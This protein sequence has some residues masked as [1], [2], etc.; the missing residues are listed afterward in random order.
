MQ[1]AVDQNVSPERP[2]GSVLVV[3]DEEQIRRLV[4][5]ALRR[6]GYEVTVAADGEE[7]LA[8]IAEATPDLVVSDVMMPGL[9]GFALLS[10][11]R[12]DPATR[13]IPVILL[14]AKGALE[15]R[16]TGLTLGADDYLPKPF[17]MA[18][19]L[20]RVR[21]KIERPPVPSDE[22]PRDRQTRL[23][24]ERS[25]LNALGREVERASRSGRTGILAFL[26][27][28]ELP[29]IRQ[30]LGT[31]AD[32]AVAKQFASLLL[33]EA[34][35]LDVVARD[36]EGRFAMLIPEISPEAA[37]KRLELL[38]QRIVQ[39]TFTAAGEQVRLT[40]VIGFATFDGETNAAGVREQALI[41]LAVAEIR[42]DLQPV[43]YEP[44]LSV[45]VAN[46][47]AG[48]IRRSARWPKR[49]ALRTP[50]QIVFTYLLGMGVP[51]LAYF[52]FSG[53]GIDV[54]Q[55]MYCVVVVSLLVTSFFIW[56]EGFEALR[57]TEIPAQPGAPYPPATA[58]IAAYLPNEA[59][60]IAD[61]IEAFLR[62]EYPGPLQIILAYNTPRDLPVEARLREIAQRDS[63]FLPLRVRQSTSKAQNVNAALAEATG[64][65]VGIFD[66]DHHP[67]PDSFERAWRWL[68]NGYDVVQGHCVIRNGAESWVSK[69]VAVEF[70]AIY[71]VSHPGRARLHG[72]GI[73]GGSNGYWKTEMLRRI[74]MHGFM[75]TEDIDSSLRVIESGGK[76]ACDP[77]LISRE[78]A[79]VTF[80]ALWNQRMRWAQGWFQV[81]LKHL[82]RGVRS[83]HLTL[84]QKLGL[85]YLL[86]WREIYPWLSFQIFPIIAFWAWEKG[87]LDQLD[88]LIP[89]FVLTTLF[90]LSAGPGQTLFAYL[91]AVPEIRQHRWWFWRYL[92]I[93]V[94]AYTELK[95]LIARV[96]QHKEVMRERQWK[97]TPRAATAE[98]EQAS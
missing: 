52:T 15:D 48:S 16:V 40:P 19:L 88:W 30:R 32:A 94:L 65:F 13:A 79:P 57:P 11:L 1:P 67:A 34:G 31:R 84:R 47:R 7:A 53:H 63:R 21:A 9:D 41:A 14:T 82:W 36:H 93:S 76:I 55:P 44:K 25:L 64:E 72:F 89:I 39:A 96:A 35:A 49:E 69:T 77:Q 85:A 90:T 50:M 45:I 46:H 20:A 87:G 6:A 92:I 62:I 70:E 23:L 10:K 74:R 61:T 26:T 68:S 43:R 60:T 12:A 91:L 81:S 24:S 80:R 73:F 54:A 59:A 66:A 18:E 58:V 37:Q 17:E 78:L 97:V 27:L 33:S 98:A 29:R 22:L 51:L 56:I 8:R 75:L 38:A 3:D 42:L 5:I 2:R 95:N 86:G 71:A 4:S 83:P 28:D